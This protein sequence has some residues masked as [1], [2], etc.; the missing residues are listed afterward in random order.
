MVLATIV[1]SSQLIMSSISVDTSKW[2]RMLG[3][4]IVV[5]VGVSCLLGV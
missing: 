5:R 2:N 1:D 4:H 3:D